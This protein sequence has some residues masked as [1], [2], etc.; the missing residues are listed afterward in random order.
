MGKRYL[1]DTNTVIDYLDNKLNNKA[2]ELI[3][4]TEVQISV[5]SR[6][7]L[8]VWTKASPQQL[9]VLNLF[10][11]ASTLYNLEE[12]I[13][14]KTIEVRKKYRLKLPDAIIAATALAYD[15]TLITHNTNDFKNIQEL[16]IL[17][18]HKL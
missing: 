3:E 16:Q 11:L 8:L 15:L 1:I 5:V 2:V 14:L 17:D 9:E 10:I 7:E 6:I 4:T 12:N 18:P 13:I